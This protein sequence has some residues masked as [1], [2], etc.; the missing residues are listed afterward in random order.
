MQPCQFHLRGEIDVA[1]ASGLVVTLRSV[2]GLQPTA[3]EIVVD[4]AD[5]MFIDAA[6]IG[7]LVSVA[8]ELAEEG[9]TLRLVHPSRMLV[10]LLQILDLSS[11][12]RCRARIRGASGA[13]SPGPGAAGN[14]SRHTVTARPAGVVIAEATRA[15]GSRACDAPL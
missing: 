2:A 10:R 1:T 8:N 15:P 13:A 3:R 11:M 7:A 5:L 14:R 9:R 4:C 6:G 12:I